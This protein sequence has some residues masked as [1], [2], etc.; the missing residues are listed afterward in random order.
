[1][2]AR[3]TQVPPTA[4]ELAA[5][6]DAANAKVAEDAP[7]HLF[8]K[9]FTAARELYGFAMCDSYMPPPGPV[10][11]AYIPHWNINLVEHAGAHRHRVL[12]VL[13]P[14]GSGRG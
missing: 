2:Y 8:V 10:T 6:E 4:A 7:V 13:H 5:I 1:M 14:G 11:I 9:D 12:D 3:A